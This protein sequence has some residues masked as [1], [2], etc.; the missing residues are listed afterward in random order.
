MHEGPL[1][2]DR[3]DIEGREGYSQRAA[4][5]KPRGGQDSV[6]AAS[7]EESEQNQHRGEHIG[8]KEV[9]EALEPVR[10]G[11]TRSTGAEPLLHDTLFLL[12][13]RMSGNQTYANLLAYT[14]R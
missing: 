5:V 3:K 1:H 6:G 14:P 4:R 12:K 13:C 2:Y 7:G 11:N 8:R 9:S 10:H